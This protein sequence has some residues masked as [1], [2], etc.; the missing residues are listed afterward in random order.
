MKKIVFIGSANVDLVFETLCVPKKGETIHGDSFFL[1][2][3]GKEQ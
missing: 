3:G 2:V 1:S